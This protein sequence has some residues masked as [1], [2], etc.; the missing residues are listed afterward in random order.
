MHGGSVKTAALDSA[1]L[2]LLAAILILPLFRVAYFDNWMSIDGAF[3]GD[4]RF[5]SEHLPASG[6]VPDFYCG[7]RFDY[8]YPPAL[9]Y[10]SAWIARYGGFNPAHGYHIYSALLYCLS[11]AGIYALSRV[12]GGSRIWASAAAVAALTLSPV[13][14]LFKDIRND[15][16]LHMPQHLNVIV[17]W[18]EAPHMAAMSV[19][20]FALAASWLALRGSRPGMSGAAAVLCALCVSNNFYGAT[21][22]AISFPLMVWTLWVTDDPP[23]VWL[24]AAGI[25]VLSY[26]LTA[27]WLTPSYLRLTA[28]NLKLVARPGDLRSRLVALG[29]I[30]LFGGISF[31]VGRRKPQRAWPIFLSGAVALF[32]LN[33]LGGYYF[34]FH[35]LGEP[36]R[37]VPEFD[38]LLI[39]GAVECLRRGSM[40]VRAGGGLLL[41]ASLVAALPYLGNPWGVYMGDDHPERRIEYRLSGWLARNLPGA[42]VHIASSLGFWSHVW[43]DVPQ[44]GGVSDQGM[45]NQI[46]A[47]ANWQIIRN[48]NPARDVYWLQALGADA[49]VVHGK[50]SQEI[51]HAVRPDKFAGLLP[52]LFDDGEDDVVYRVP[53][54]FPGLARVVERSRMEALPAIEWSDDNEAQLRAY[55][56]ALEQGPNSPASSEWVSPRK[57]RIRARIGEG[58]SVAVQETYDSGWRAYSDGR[59]LKV[60]RDVIGF[61]RIDTP[62]GEHAIDLVFETPLENRVGR[63]VSLIAVLVV[64]LLGFVRRFWTNAE[65]HPVKAGGTSSTW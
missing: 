56:E 30:S 31:V 28:A 58:E 35:A 21:A 48:D 45:E 6:W 20:L 38:L 54:R 46:I 22:L 59:R 32:G 41:G 13:M 16:A 49:L 1:L 19:L 8:L 64:A 65:Q 5:L 47:L 15:S 2:I 43:N 14:L 7:N 52:V 4:A 44:I 60:S 26:A 62:A 51:Y 36:A 12:A 24:R 40:A 53:R 3:I 63:V 29:L 18:G 61:I 23:R 39:L 34:E 17:R 57:M 37:F 11:I 27:W 10:G 33:A 42:R 25:A 9:R 50:R 55:V